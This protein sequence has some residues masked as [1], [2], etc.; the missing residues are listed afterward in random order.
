MGRPPGVKNKEGYS[1]TPSAYHQRSVAALKTG[2][3]SAIMQNIVEQMELTPEQ[4]EL[5][6]AERLNAW[7][8]L[9]T[10]ALFIADQFIDIKTV[11]DAKL[12][13]GMDPAGK[14][15]REMMKLMLEFTKEY[16]KLTQVS[17]DKKME[18]FSRSFS[19]TDDL[20]FDVAVEDG[21]DE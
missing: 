11:V 12:M 1:M 18:A 15:Y 10:P 9:S 20:V 13:K 8:R 21:Q 16:N 6:S 4:T 5:L 3:H 2:R 14:D 7:K 19:T 17:A